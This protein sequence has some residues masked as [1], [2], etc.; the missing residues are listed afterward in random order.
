MGSVSVTPALRKQRQ[1]DLRFQA[2]LVRQ[3]L[4]NSRQARKQTPSTVPQRIKQMGWG[5]RQEKVFLEKVTI[6]TLQL[7]IESTVAEDAEKCSPQE[8]LLFFQGTWVSSQQPCPLA[9]NCL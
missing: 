2:S 8:R 4:K 1:E 3:C 5:R 9:C 7:S 6:Q